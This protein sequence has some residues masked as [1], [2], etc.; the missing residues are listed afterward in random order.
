MFGSS[1]KSATGIHVAD[2]AVHIVELARRRSETR[3]AHAVSLELP[4]SLRPNRLAD[5]AAAAAL[6]AALEQA[7]LD[8]GFAYRH[9]YYALDG[10]AF[11]LKRR[12]A[13]PDDPDETRQLLRWEATQVL[14]DDL[15]EYVIDFL[16][17]R[18]HGFLVAARRAAID[19]VTATLRQAHIAR[20]GFDVLPFALCNALELSGA[21]TEEGVEILADLGADQA[22]LIALADGELE[23]VEICPYR[24][25][26]GVVAP[27]RPSPRAARA[28]SEGLFDEVEADDTA[29]EVV[30]H[31]ERC[32]MVAE[33]IE[34]MAQAQGGERPGRL[35]LTGAADE[36]W[37]DG[38]SGTGLP[39]PRILD[40][41][42]GMELSAP[43]S[44]DGAA[45]AG[46]LAAA[47]GLA[48]RGLAEA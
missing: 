12:P 5:P 44:R 7:R 17:T 29:G 9:C 35:W 19:V 18:R 25:R 1:P 33:A 6:R 4:E 22:T 27:E 10:G 28:G 46:A 45:P 38:L 20:P 43:A 8:R 39:R 13:I 3:L 40:A 48:F 42:A 32:R 24:R 11:F 15:S 31:G 2:R 26:W 14:A 21:A 36:V 34:R 41:L 30:G 16:L 47:A 37:I 23:D